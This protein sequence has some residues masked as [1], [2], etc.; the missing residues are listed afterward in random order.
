MKVGM[1]IY[2]TQPE[3]VEPLAE[4][5]DYIEVLIVPDEPFEY[6]RDY[7]I[8]FRI[9]AAHQGFGVNFADST[10][11][12]FSK[13]AVAQASQAAYKLNSPTVV[14]HPGDGNKSEALKNL[15]PLPKLACD[16]SLLVENLPRKP[17]KS[18]LLNF[19]SEASE[20]LSLG[21]GLCLDIG[22]A[23]GAA[24]S[25]DLDYEEVIREFMALD[26]HYFHA[27]NGITAS[28]YDLHMPL[29]EGE[30]DF[31]FFKKEILKHKD[32]WV[33]L[34]TPYNPEENEREYKYFKEVL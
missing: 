31:T 30:F 15:A 25:K 22:H 13:K 26:P 20:Y 3:R 5:A 17:G 28:T 9:H 34:E 23:A 33:T 29:M 4:F 10:K 2:S 1:K 19:A 8:P 14:I 24:A 12:E 18:E 16:L 21:F 32:P 6:L 27:S 11:A 7:T